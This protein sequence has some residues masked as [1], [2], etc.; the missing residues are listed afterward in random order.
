MNM[1]FYTYVISFSLKHFVHL[2]LLSNFKS[3]LTQIFFMMSV[4]VK[5]LDIKLLFCIIENRDIKSN[6]QP[7]RQTEKM[8]SIVLC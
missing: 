3:F 2:F 7:K 4:K 1:V 8:G 5:T 6:K